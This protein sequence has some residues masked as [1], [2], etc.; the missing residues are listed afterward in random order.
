MQEVSIGESMSENAPI[1]WARSIV[2]ETQIFETRLNIPNDIRLK[3]KELIMGFGDCQDRKTNVK[4]D[5][6]PWRVAEGIPEIMIAIYHKLNICAEHS[7]LRIVP[8]DPSEPSKPVKMLF[9]DTWGA[10]YRENDYA[11]THSHEPSVFSFVYFVECTPES[12]PLRF[13]SPNGDIDVKPD[14]DKLVVFPSHLKHGV[15]PQCFYDGIDI[16]PRIIIAG[17]AVPTESADAVYLD[18]EEAF[19]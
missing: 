10:T 16:N 13:I 17:N 12:S 15:P 1:I 6:T 14:I 9:R 2:A 4:A 7:H 11:V 19:K 3:A 8:N 5:M 18:V